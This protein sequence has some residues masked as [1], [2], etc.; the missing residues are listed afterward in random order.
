MMQFS[1]G[2]NDA[3]IVRL[4]Q[5][6]NL[7]ISTIEDLLKSGWIYQEDIHKP[8]RWLHPLHNLKISDNS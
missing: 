3:D 7:D 8:P 4:A 5:R 6:C 1:L 2:P